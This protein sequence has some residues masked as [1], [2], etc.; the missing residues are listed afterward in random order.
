MKKFYLKKSAIVASLVVAFIA[1]SCGLII[2]EFT[3]D[4]HT[5]MQGENITVTAKIE[6]DGAEFQNNADIYLYYGVRVPNDWEVI[7]LKVIDNQLMADPK[8]FEFEDSKF[9][10]K[11][12][13]VSYP[14]EGYKWVAFQTK[15]KQTIAGEPTNAELVLKVGQALGKYEIDVMGGS[16]S[17]EPSKMLLA[18]GD[19]DYNL[20][21]NNKNDNNT[22]KG[23]LYMCF[24]EYLA[25]VSTLK[26]TEIEARKL[27]L[28]NIMV[29]GLPISPM[30]VAHYQG[31][32]PGEKEKEMPTIN[33]EVEVIENTNTGGIETVVDGGKVNV[34]AVDGR[35]EV[36]AE[37]GIA[38]VYDMT[39]SIIDTK[40]V[41]GA[42]TLEARKGMCIVRVVNGAQSTVQKVIVK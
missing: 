38:T 14:R 2:T 29:N 30:D 4:N 10:S 40:V 23:Q 41:N 17:T 42:A 24:Q 20:A 16:S 21:F 12:M 26:S 18:N 9:Y 19:L 28:A 39:G 22:I 37:G 11:L 6:R 36:E 31:K 32:V 3:I 33:N 34:V 13:E 7:S 25:M 8:K 27:S 35:I 5:P 1:V 15:E